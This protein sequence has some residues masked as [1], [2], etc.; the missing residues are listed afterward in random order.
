MKCSAD[1][2]PIPLLC[3]AHTSNLGL[4]SLSPSQGADLESV[5]PP[6][7]QKERFSLS[8]TL[9]KTVTVWDIKGSA[10]S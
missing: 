7:K 1:S 3:T 5:G 8:G 6:G 4:G 9:R 2:P 10:T